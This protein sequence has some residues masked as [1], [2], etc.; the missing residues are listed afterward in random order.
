MGRRISLEGETKLDELGVRQ[1]SQVGAFEGMSF[2]VGWHEAGVIIKRALRT[3]PSN[4]GH[5]WLI[6]RLEIIII[7]SGRGGCGWKYVGR[8]LLHCSAAQFIMTRFGFKLLAAR[9]TVKPRI[10]PGTR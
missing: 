6:R 8:C 1:Q 10:P 3:P 5:T 4:L 9:K 7:I 2:C